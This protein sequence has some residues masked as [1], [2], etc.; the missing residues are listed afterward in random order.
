M[1]LSLSA[2]LFVAGWCCAGCVHPL[3]PGF[4]FMDRR[5]EIRQV[6]DGSSQIRIRVVDQMENSGDRL[7]HSLEMRL[8]PER[9]LRAQDLTVIVDGRESSPQL[10]SERDPRLRRVRF[11]PAWEQGQSREIVT[12]WSVAPGTSAS[13][14]V[15]A[16][17]AAFYL[18]D[19]TALPLWQ[20]PPGIFTRGGPDAIKRSLTVL[21]PPDFRVLGPGKLERTR[22]EGDHIAYFFR[23]RKNRM[24]MPFVVAGRYQQLVLRSARDSVSY[25]T[26]Q[27]LDPQQAESATARLASSMRAFAD[28]FGSDSK[29]KTMIHIVE[30]PGE[31]PSVFGQPGSP[32]G[33]SF[34]GGVLLD[35][36][37]W[38]QGISSEPVLE[39]A[40]VELARTWFG[41]RVRPETSA[42]LLMG[43]GAQLFGLVV[44]AEARAED[45]RRQMVSSLLE[46]Y[47]EARRTAPDQPLLGPPGGY[48][49]AQRLSTGYKAALFFVALEDVCG[50]ENFR[51]ALTHLVRAL[52]GSEAGAEEFRAAAEAAS[53]RNLA[54]MFRVWIGHPGIPEDFRARY[55]SPPTAAG[56][57]F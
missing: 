35:R 2:A 18:A 9:V 46:G 56:P 40:E 30:A 27:S 15:A 57:L 47:D 52:G 11:S 4:R 48:S 44:A 31:L 16:S 53:G 26:F 29:G 5:A 12:E 38:E 19:A 39:L 33:T 23:K 21:V 17:A 13:G 49:P 36:R 22:R 1:R 37:G 34:P 10:V 20:A 42:Q 25:W 55:T 14:N 50:R 7:L 6:P 24:F 8:P 54:E 41:W 3:G 51:A 43:R 28:Y 32:G 45:Q